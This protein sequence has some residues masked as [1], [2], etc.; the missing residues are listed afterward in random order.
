M[1]APYWMNVNKDLIIG[2]FTGLVL[3]L[4]QGLREIP[5]LSQALT[6]SETWPMYTAIG[7]LLGFFVGV[8]L[9]SRANPEPKKR[10]AFACAVV[11][12]ISIGFLPF[13]RSWIAQN[14]DELSIQV[15]IFI[16]LAIAMMIGGAVSHWFSKK[17][18][19]P[20]E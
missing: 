19:Q 16:G 18:T 12:A 9:I 3:G 10:A 5:L 6:S 1:K 14:L 8:H 13:I 4:P 7:V 15:P 17:V 11:I 20:Q 2:A